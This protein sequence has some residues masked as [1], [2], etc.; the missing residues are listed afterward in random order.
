MA[1]KGLRNLKAAYKINPNDFELKIKLADVYVKKGQ[2]ID[3]A[4]KLAQEAH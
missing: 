4:Y 1:D 3:E 2:N